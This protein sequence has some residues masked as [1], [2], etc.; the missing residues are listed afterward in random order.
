MDHLDLK[1]LYPRCQPS[2]GNTSYQITRNER[3]LL[4]LTRRKLWIASRHACFLGVICHGGPCGPREIK[5]IT[6]L[7][8]LSATSLRGHAHSVPLSLSC[9][10]LPSFEVLPLSQ[11][12]GREY[13]ETHCPSQK[14]IL[15]SAATWNYSCYQR[16]P[17]RTLRS[18]E[19]TIDN[20]FQVKLVK[21]NVLLVDH[22]RV[23]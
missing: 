18:S 19:P 13:C 15:K 22:F 11:R 14:A 8:F 12:G 2:P 9:A 20:F 10:T 6:R 1:D 5:L 7:Q 17:G 16:L 21:K 3:I 23:K 4:R